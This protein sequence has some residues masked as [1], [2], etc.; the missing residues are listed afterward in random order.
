MG[1]LQSRKCEGTRQDS[2]LVET[3]HDAMACIKGRRVEGIEVKVK[4][5][6][7]VG[8]LA[9]AARLVASDRRL[10]RGTE[11]ARQCWGRC[12]EGRLENK[13]GGN[14]RRRSM[15]VTYRSDHVCQRALCRMC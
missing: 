6:R 7:L 2:V 10:S 15:L 3:I 4:R 8:R 12:S 11:G 1:A 9:R 13:G 14:G 5:M